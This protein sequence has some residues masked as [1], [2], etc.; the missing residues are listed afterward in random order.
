MIA[1]MQKKMLIRLKQKA[2]KRPLFGD[3]TTPVIR[4]SPKTFVVEDDG[5]GTKIK[6]GPSSLQRAFN[7]A[8]SRAEVAA[9]YYLLPQVAC[10]SS[11]KLNPVYDR[12]C[13]SDPFML[14]ERPCES[15]IDEARKLLSDEQNAGRNPSGIEIEGRGEFS[16]TSLSVLQTISSERN[17]LLGI[18]CSPGDL[19]LI[20]NAFWHH[21][22]TNPLLRHER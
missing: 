3:S 13:V 10:R 6:A 21:P 8:T 18:N 7:Y 12:L 4:P 16:E 17:W 1:T 11:A 15:D 20:Q 14:S 9:L 2:S 5:G 19:A 22:A